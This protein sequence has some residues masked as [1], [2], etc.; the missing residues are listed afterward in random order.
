MTTDDD[1]YVAAT[2]VKKGW[3]P[4]KPH[5]HRFH[6]PNEGKYGKITHDNGEEEVVWESD[7]T[8]GDIYRCT[9]DDYFTYSQN[10]VSY[11]YMYDTVP[12][13]SHWYRTDREGRPYLWTNV[14]PWW[15]KMFGI[16]D[17]RYVLQEEDN[18]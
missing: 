4:A 1:A 16:N 13:T 5:Q 12:G 11:M 10:S 15:K 17:M 7:L 18:D 3:P 6:L 8:H 14:A 2:L 9:C